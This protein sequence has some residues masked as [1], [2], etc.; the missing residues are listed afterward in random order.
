MKNYYRT[1][2]WYSTYEF[3]SQQFY[4]IRKYSRF[5][6]V[7]KTSEPIRTQQMEETKKGKFRYDRF[8]REGEIDVPTEQF[9]TSNI[10]TVLTS[11]PP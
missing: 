6:Q 11:A 9:G 5:A 8:G 3:K 1:L 7:R 2:N 10:G 4:L